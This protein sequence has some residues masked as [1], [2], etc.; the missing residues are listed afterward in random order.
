MQEANLISIFI[1]P[2]NIANIEY[3]ITG[4][5]A[6]ILYGEPRMTHD[7]DL[8]INLSEKDVLGIEKVFPSNQYYCPP[9][10]LIFTEIS[11]TDA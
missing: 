4:S 8:V 1:K 7:I 2:L 11:K 6:S 9:E 5:V 10:D 3:M